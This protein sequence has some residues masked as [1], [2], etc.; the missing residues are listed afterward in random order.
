M[1]ILVLNS[2]SSTIKYKIFK[3]LKEIQSGTIKNTENFCLTNI[4][5][6]NTIDAVGHRVVHGGEQFHQAV[7]IDTKVINGIRDLIPLAPLHNPSNLKYIEDI[8]LKFPNLNQ[9]A[10]FDTAFHQTI[11]KKHYLYP[12]PMEY[13]KQNHIRKYGFH[14]TSVEYITKR[15]AVNK[16]IFIEDVNIIILHIGGGASA[17][18]IQDGKSFDTSMGFTPLEGLMMGTRCGDIDPEIPLYLQ[19]KA[20]MTY[21]EVDE[22]LNKKSGLKG[23]CGTNDFK[24]IIE[25]L[26]KEEFSLA[27][28]MFC[29]RVKEYIG[30]YWI[31]SRKLDAVVF[32]GGIGE[33]SQLLRDT[34]CEG[35]SL[36]VEVLVIPT[37]EELE[38]AIQTQNLLNKKGK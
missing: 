5:D 30:K 25:N 14:G 4:V 24:E 28:E 27:F 38:I 3:N 35:V 15:Y 1:T 26:D 19:K 13:Y 6:L 9:V 11:D 33:N 10:V 21:E 34:V 29:L 7:N 31:Q 2:G 37:N 23:I 8:A 20:D 22:L 17:T 36:D 16:N 12:I 18:L 32:T